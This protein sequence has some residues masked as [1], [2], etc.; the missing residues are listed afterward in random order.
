MR[1]DGTAAHFHCPAVAA[2]N[3]D[4]V[5]PITGSAVGPIKG[6][7]MLT[8]A[9]AADSTAEKWNFSLHTAANPNGEIRGQVTVKV[10]TERAQ[11]GGVSRQD[12]GLNYRSR[13]SAIIIRV[14]QRTT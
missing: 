14:T 10:I 6:E 1:G 4:F 11:Y 5:V 7:A 13:R 9:Q 12:V 3:A 2:E 8:G